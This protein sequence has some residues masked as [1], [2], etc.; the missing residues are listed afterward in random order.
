MGE[1]RRECISQTS[2]NVEE[3]VL[4]AFVLYTP[5]TDEQWRQKRKCDGVYCE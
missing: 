5:T 4:D 2:E 3:V 1:G